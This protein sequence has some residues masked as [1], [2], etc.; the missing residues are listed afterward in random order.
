V[1]SWCEGFVEEIGSWHGVSIVVNFS[2]MAGRVSSWVSR[3]FMV[4]SWWSQELM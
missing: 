2:T 4:S 1:P 3:E